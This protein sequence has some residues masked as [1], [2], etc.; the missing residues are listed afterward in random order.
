M[1]S[2][3]PALLIVS[4]LS[5]L[6]LC[7]ALAQP[8]PPIKPK[9]SI[10][11]RRPIPT[12]QIQRICD[13][14]DNA[15]VACLLRSQLLQELPPE[16]FDRMQR[17]FQDIYAQFGLDQGKG[18]LAAC[19]HDNW[20]AYGQALR[21]PTSGVRIT[22]GKA[23]A[24]TRVA[25]A[26]AAV[27]ACRGA[28]ISAAGGGAPSPTADHDRWV[29]STVAAVDQAM[30]SCRDSNNSLIAAGGSGGFAPSELL[31][32]ETGAV[33]GGFRFTKLEGRLS[34]SEM[35]TVRLVLDAVKS[36][37]KKIDQ[38]KKAADAIP[39]P[40]ERQKAQDKVAG[41]SEWLLQFVEDFINLL[42]HFDDDTTPPPAGDPPA[43][44]ASQCPQDLPCGSTCADKQASWQAF[45][46]MCAMSHW[47]AYNCETFLRKVNSCP[48]VT[49]IN[50]GPDGDLSCP[51]RKSAKEQRAEA[52]QQ[53]CKLKGWVMMPVPGTQLTCVRPD[54][55]QSLPDR[56]DVCSDPRAM[57][58]PDQCNGPNT[59]AVDEGSPAPRPD[60]RR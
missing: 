57:P 32:S 18:N 11:I 3:M 41:E 21:T 27:T 22:S 24:G 12:L 47:Q 55:S 20:A 46:D 36:A 54:L 53:Q 56:L 34:P 50:P 10:V 26:S 48:D 15:R 13:V 8:V 35:L 25:D 39:D 4:T 52:Y 37:E 60:P 33:G 40:V 2:R 44:A 30:S 45:K 9:R 23:L 1:S 14:H 5:L 28:A 6:Y 42:F 19:G 51:A 7:A 29:N 49:R 17:L 43:A 58:G 31:E 16:L 38:D 59:P